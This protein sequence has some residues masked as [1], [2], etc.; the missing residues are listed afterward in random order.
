MK[1][2]PKCNIEKPIT[3]FSHRSGVRSKEFR[4]YCKECETHNAR[5]WQ[6]NVGEYYLNYKKSYK[7]ANRDKFNFYERKRKFVLRSPNLFGEHT[8]E[9]WY[10]LKEKYL[11]KCL[12]CG[13]S[14]P[15]VKLTEDHIIPISKGGGNSI[16]NIQPLCIKCNQSK[17]DRIIYY[18]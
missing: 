7:K 16:D 13:V 3:A 10:A 17:N 18:E 8:I 4:S 6:K 9:E 2:C 12:C 1:R 5:G 15:K 14:E 11:N